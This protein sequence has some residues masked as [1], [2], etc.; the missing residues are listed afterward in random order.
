[1]TQRGFRIGLSLAVLTALAAYCPTSAAER[2]SIPDRYRW[3]LADLY[4][5]EEGWIQARTRV[6]DSVREIARLRGTLGGSAES[7]HRAFSAW[8]GLLHEVTRLSA[9][10]S[11]LYDLDQ[12]I[13]RSQQMDQEAQQV[14]TD[15]AAAVS[16]IEPELLS[17][18]AEK[19]REYVA[20]YPPL[21]EYRQPIEDILRRAP[22]TLSPEVEKVVAQAGSLA[23]AGPDIRGIFVNADLPYPEVTLKSGEKVRVDAAAYT[24]HRAATSREDRL[25]VFRE[26]WRTYNEF[27]RTLG[28]ALNAH[29][30]AHVFEKEVRSHGSCLEAALFRDNIPVRVYSRLLEDVRANL[31]TLHR[32]LRLRQRM[33]GLNRLGYEDLYASI[34]PAFGRTFTPEE[35]MEVTLNAVAPLGKEYQEI[36]RKGFDSRWVDWLPSP[37]KRSGAY[38]NTVYGVHPYQL[39]NFTGLYEEVSTLAHEAGHSMHSF[40]SN[41]AQPYPTHDYPIFLAE[42]AST[43][44]ENL[45]FHS[46]LAGAKDDDTRLFLLGSYLD[47]LRTTLFRQTLFA[48]FELRIHERVERGEPLTGSALNALYLGMVRE[49]YGH[50]GE[51]CEVAEA[52]GAEWA[53]IPHFFY[54]FYVYQYATSVLAAVSLADGFRSEA[55]GTSHSTAR[56]DGYL[57]MLSAGSSRY[58]FDLLKDAGVDLTTS[59]PFQAAMREMNRIIDE[60]EDILARR[61]AV[62]N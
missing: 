23:S 26:F 43:L 9:Y 29:V 27:T 15:V 50:D 47:N 25:L 28:T 53:Y 3:N 60:M 16:W 33:M 21:G 36:L 4:P 24:K 13:G 18:G 37:G 6:Q 51:V 46:M 2:D 42:V 10:A 61:G 11:Q 58:A 31:P 38:S 59:A 48:E 14:R 34:V 62:K 19:V 55:E 44:N 8:A 32:Y 35:A 22:H 40:L 54:N 39:Q 20:A 1:M 49:Y 57:K 30:R 5:S 12:R 45:L 41:R 17:V 52:Y 7:L 56:R